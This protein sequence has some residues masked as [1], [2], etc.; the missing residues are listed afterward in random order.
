MWPGQTWL[1]KSLN[2]ACSNADRNLMRRVVV[3]DDDAGVAAAI[4]KFLE[5]RG[6]KTTFATS[7][8]AG[9]ELVLATLPDAVVCDMRMPGLGGEQVLLMLKAQP[10]TCN[11]PVVIVTGYCSPEFRGIGD[12][13]LVKP[14]KSDELVDAIEHLAA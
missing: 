7:G 10:T 6:Y 3:I 13:F 11:I 5:F 4:A 1:L 9:I 12:A 2:T 14:F 8:A